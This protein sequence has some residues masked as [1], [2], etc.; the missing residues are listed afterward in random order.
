[1][2]FDRR[3]PKNDPHVIIQL[4]GEDD[5]NWFEIGNG[6]SSYWLEDLIIVLRSAL[7]TLTSSGDFEREPKQENGIQ[8]G[9]RF[10]RPR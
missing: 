7:E 10:K 4:M 2:R 3:S 8:Y 5:G 9:F 6:F 1:V